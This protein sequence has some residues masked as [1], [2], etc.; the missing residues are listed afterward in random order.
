MFFVIDR[1][2]LV[3]GGGMVWAFIGVERAADEL[4]AKRQAA[5]RWSLPAGQ[6]RAQRA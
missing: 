4:G 3:R 2:V 1:L 5:I 6:L